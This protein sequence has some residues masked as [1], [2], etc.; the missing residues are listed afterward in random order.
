MFLYLYT[1]DFLY[2]IPTVVGQGPGYFDPMGWLFQLKSYS[3]L[4]LWQ[5]L[6][7]FKIPFP[8]EGR[9]IYKKGKIMLLFSKSISIMQE[10][11]NQCFNPVL[12]HNT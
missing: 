1:C 5:P 7:L 11:L 10:F 4:L 9:L 3:Y 12:K 6:L 2:Y 8:Y